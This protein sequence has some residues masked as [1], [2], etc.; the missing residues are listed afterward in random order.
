MENLLAIIVFV[1]IAVLS[2]RGSKKKRQAPPQ[3]ETGDDYVPANIDFDIPHIEGAPPEN[4][5]PEPPSE[6]AAATPTPHS[7]PQIAISQSTAPRRENSPLRLTAENTLQAM[8]W[9]QILGRPK[10]YRR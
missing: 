5:F 6:T 10:G 3:A 1:L 2:D 9:A 4:Y 7:T 8:A